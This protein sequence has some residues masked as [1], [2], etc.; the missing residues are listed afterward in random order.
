[1]QMLK[2][3]LDLAQVYQRCVFHSNER[4]DSHGHVARALS[5][6]DLRWQRGAPDT[7]L[8][9]ARISRLQLFVLRYGAQV[10][11]TPSPFDDFALVH[12]SLKGCAEFDCDGRRV[13][14]PEGKVAVVAP[15]KNLRLWWE[16]GSEQLILKVPHALLHDLA[17]A[18]AQR[19]A[20][21]GLHPGLHSGLLQSNMM[22][23]QWGLLMQSLLQILAQ[24]ADL[25]THAAWIDHFERNIGLFLLA[26]QGQSA[27]PLAAGPHASAAFESGQGLATASA[28]QRMDALERYMRA[29]LCA[30]VSLLD[31]AMAAGVSV[32][33]LNM[34]CHRHHGVPPMDL[35][36]NM[37]LDAAHAVLKERPDASVTETAFEF[38]FCHLGRFSAYYRQRFGVL[39]KHTGELMH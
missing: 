20:N 4:V 9:Q 1:M 35:L 5:D 27:P 32:R 7:A 37:R 16:E 26:Q 18:G 6:H 30:P 36:R 15:K 12:M 22:E 11:V 21:A 28:G 2:G 31:L 3:S 24:P 39:P 34:L 38:G 8:F 14:V 19:G 29:K 23:M 25:P 10:E 17:P 13:R 33:T